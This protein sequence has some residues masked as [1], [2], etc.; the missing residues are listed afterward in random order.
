MKKKLIFFLLFCSSIMSFS[1]A[2]TVNIA[3]W[4]IRINIKNDSIAGNIWGNRSRA[5]VDMVLFYD[6]DFMGVQEDYEKEL[7]ELNEKLPDYKRVGFPNHEN[8]FLGSFNT[9]FYKKG[10]FAIVDRGMFYLSPEEDKPTLGWNAKYIRSCSWA[11]F[12]EIGKK[13]YYLVFNTHTDYAG[14]E[15][16]RESSKLLIKKINLLSKKSDIV[17]LM[18][19]LNFNQRGEGYRILNNS[20]VI[21]DAYDLT[22][23]KMANNGTFNKF[24]PNH[25]SNDRVDHIFVSPQVSVRKYG[26]L[27]ESYWYENSQRLPSDHYPVFIQIDND[28]KKSYKSKRK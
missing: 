26:I 1:F 2:E 17:L 15:S 5:I 6:F 27:T 28:V 4:N 3:T 16:E 21:K 11:R 19:D 8:G 18:G 9:I 7:N 12:K 13:K 24:D 20:E 22:L 14:G 10:R 25:V 23:L